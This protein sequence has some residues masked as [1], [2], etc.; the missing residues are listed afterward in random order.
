MT[1]SPH[2]DP[3]DDFLSALDREAADEA[4][5]TESRVLYAELAKR[6]GELGGAAQ[7]PADDQHL[8]EQI[9]SEARTRSREIAGGRGSERRAKTDRPIP[10]WL[11][12]AWL[13]AVG[14][15][16]LLWWKL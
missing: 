9:L 1:T 11:V 12:F 8:S 15:A 14:L 13:L 6:R 5:R 16:V 4:E 3:P 7:I 2:R 10:W